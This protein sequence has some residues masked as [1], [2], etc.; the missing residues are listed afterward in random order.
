MARKLQQEKDPAAFARRLQGKAEGRFRVVG[1]DLGTNC[2]IAWS[3]IKP[4]DVWEDAVIVA[5]QLNLALGQYDTGPLRHIRLKQFLSVLA[6]DL[7]AFEDVK[8][9]PDKGTFGGKGVGIIVARVSSAAELLGGF[10]ITLATWAEENGVPAHG[11]AIGQIKKY[12][13][14]KGSAN[15]EAMITAANEKYGVSLSVDD[16]KS[17]GADNIA[18]AMHVCAM[19]INEYGAGLCSTK[20]RKTRTDNVST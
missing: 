9:T 15:K 8:F 7:I 14:G 11:Y 3:D 6:P 20:A 18:D 17:T 12:A 2:G 4:G 19:A 5:G 16:Y 1:L 13:T 10:K